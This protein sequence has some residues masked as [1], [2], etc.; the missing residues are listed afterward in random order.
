MLV[1]LAAV[2]CI[3]KHLGQ[4]TLEP[5]VI[6]AYEIHTVDKVTGEVVYET[7]ESVKERVVYKPIEEVIERVEYEPVERANLNRVENPRLLSY[8]QL[9]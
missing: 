5:Q 2:F 9:S 8:F 3:G 6:V 7:G 4:V 1:I